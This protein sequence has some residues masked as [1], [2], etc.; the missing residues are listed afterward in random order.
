MYLN[1]SVFVCGC[2]ADT[3]SLNRSVSDGMYGAEF[4][5]AVSCGL[6]ALL[7]KKFP[8]H[9]YANTLPLT[10]IHTQTQTHTQTH[11]Q[12]PKQTQTHPNGIQP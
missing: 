6:F 2:V 1:A 7:G 4:Y 5:S 10:E 12:T 8:N 11:T 9:T 3:S